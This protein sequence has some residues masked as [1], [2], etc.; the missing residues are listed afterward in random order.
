[1]G[2]PGAG[3]G[4]QAT[5]IAA[6]YGIPA[7]SSG[8]LFRDNIRRQTDLGR[9][10]SA[11]I[12]GGD[13]VPDVLTSSLVFRRLL[14]PDCGNGWLLDG[15][16]RTVG[17]VAALDLAMRERGTRLDA[18]I[19]LQAHPDSLV[20]RLLKRAEIEG[21]A[22]DNEETIRHRIDIYER[23]TAELLHVYDMRG[24]VVKVDAIGPVD[25]VT[26]RL[27]KALD[28]KLDPR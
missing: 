27:A 19:T 21:R 10:I 15:Y 20:E 3:K 24:L 18:V 7:I 11:L 6:H 22:D 1:M 9:R 23:Q 26:A 17:Q 8:D 16:P 14:E 13:Y 4:T 28:E 5:G 2:P 12:A 25:D